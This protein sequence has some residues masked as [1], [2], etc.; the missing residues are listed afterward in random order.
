MTLTARNDSHSVII[1]NQGIGTE[2]QSPWEGNSQEGSLDS[3]L[4]REAKVQSQEN[5]FKNQVPPMRYGHKG[6][7]ESHFKKDHK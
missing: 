2:L 6:E 4:G 3:S 1:G 7:R 5:F